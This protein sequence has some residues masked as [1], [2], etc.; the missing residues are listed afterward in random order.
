MGKQKFNLPNAISQFN[1]HFFDGDNNIGNTKFDPQKAN[2]IFQCPAYESGIW[3]LKI[4]VNQ[5]VVLKAEYLYITNLGTP[6][7]YKVSTVYA[8]MSLQYELDDE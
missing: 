5:L 1:I 8:F 7:K 6:F 3:P 4:Q 2:Q